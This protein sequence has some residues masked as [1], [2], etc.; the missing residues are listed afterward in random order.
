MEEDFLPICKTEKL[1]SHVVRA[2]GVA[3]D[4]DVNRTQEL[5]FFS[6]RQPGTGQLS[7]RR[8]VLHANKTGIWGDDCKF[9]FPKLP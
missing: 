3:P 5:E 6:F 9:Q 8:A 7:A 2:L 4:P 1:F